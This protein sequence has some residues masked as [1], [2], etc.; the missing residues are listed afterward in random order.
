MNATFSSISFIFEAILLSALLVAVLAWL[1]IRLA[2]RVGLLDLPDSAPHKKH[3]QATPLAGGIALIA[4][5][6]ISAVASSTISDPAVRA[7]LLAGLIVFFFG[8]WD[9]FKG[10]SP[11]LKFVGQT[12]AVILLIILGVRIQVFESPEF[13]FGGTS[14]L[15]VTLDILLTWVWMVG[16]TNAFNFVDST[17]GLAIGLTGVAAAFFMLVTLESGQLLL[18]NQNALILGACIGL[19]YFNSPPAML[20]LGDSGAQ[21]MG[22]ILAALAIAYQPQ[23]ANQS[24]SWVVPVLLLAV[25]IFDMTLVVFSRLRRHRPVYIAAR[26][27][28]YHR[29]LSLGMN[30]NRAGV[31]MQTLSLLLGCLAFVLLTLTPLVTNSIFVG[32]IILGLLAFLYLDN[33][34]RWP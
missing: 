9:D 28:T 14:P 6:L 12:A 17:D 19:F 21:S 34:K 32:V 13:F 30:T 31:F 4:A 1:S 3:T 11:L 7:A 18:S 20:F 33:H 22:F 5:L 25:P 16:I 15:Y 26:D 24:S 27:H 29:L 10:I 2:L 23:G 8:L